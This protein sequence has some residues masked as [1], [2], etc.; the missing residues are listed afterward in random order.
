MSATEETEAKKAA[1]A[2]QGVENW[3]VQAGA[4]PKALLTL[5]KAHV[6]TKQE[7]YQLWRDGIL[8]A[9]L[10]CAE[11]LINQAQERDREWICQNTRTGTVHGVLTHTWSPDG[12]AKTWAQ[13]E[14]AQ[15][16]HRDKLKEAKDKIKKD[17]RRK[18]QAAEKEAK[19]K[20]GGAKKQKKT[21]GKKQAEDKATQRGTKRAS[22][23]SHSKAKAKR[24]KRSKGK[25][26]RKSVGNTQAA[27]QTSTPTDQPDC[28]DTTPSTANEADKSSGHV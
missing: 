18:K 2:L 9:L 22:T 7:R 3:I 4:P 6:L 10:A 8:P 20:E 19:R 26:R 23:V 16:R 14:G 28:E 24:S 1:I 11:K 21:R 25:E 27:Q 13:R 12:K 5:L 15:Q 17:K